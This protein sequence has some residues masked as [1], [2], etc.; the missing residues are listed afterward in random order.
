MG[1]LALENTHKY[2]WMKNIDIKVFNIRSSNRLNKINNC[3]K[4][5][6]PKTFDSGYYLD[7]LNPSMRK[8]FILVTKMT[9]EFME[10]E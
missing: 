3:K 2:V 5:E 9:K 7:Q 10:Q 1:C 4:D 8:K 6:L